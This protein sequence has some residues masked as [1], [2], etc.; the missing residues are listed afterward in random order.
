MNLFLHTLRVEVND[1]IHIVL[2]LNQAGWHASKTILVPSGITLFPL[3]PY[4]PQ[5]NPIERLLKYL[6]ETYLYHCL[7]KTLDEI[8]DYD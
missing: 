1:R 7:D 4:S 8:S 5:L 6:K 3:P 2:V